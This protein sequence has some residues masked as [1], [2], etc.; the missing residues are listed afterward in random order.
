MDS[1]FLHLKIISYSIILSFVITLISVC[2]VKA[3]ENTFLISGNVMDSISM[4]ALS[5]VHIRSDESKIG[6]ISS[7]NGDFEF[8]ISEVPIRLSFSIIG[9]HKKELEIDQ[10]INTVL[11]IKLI[12]KSYE[13]T[14]VTIS[15]TNTYNK[16]INNYTVL[17]YGFIGDS[18]FILQKRRSIGGQASLVILNQ[19]FDTL[20]YLKKLP[21]GAHAIF[22]DCLNS[23]HVL[24][25]DSVY[26]VVCKQ[27]VTILYKPYAIDWFKKIMGDCIFKKDGNIFF[28]HILYQG[29]GHEV[30]YYDVQS[31]QKALFV[32]YIDFQ[33]FQNMTE[34]I[35]Y[36][37]SMYYLHGIVNA[38]TNDSATIKQGHNF[39]QES[40]FIKEIGDK[41][42]KNIICE[43][44][45]TIYYINYIESKIQSFSQLGQPPKE[46]LIDSQDD[47]WETEILKDEVNNEFYTCTQNNSDYYL[48][49]INIKK[50]IPEFQMKLSVFEGYNFQVNN[51]YLYYLNY[52]SRSVYHIRK[53]SRI[54]IQ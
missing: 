15:N 40:R 28:E 29:Y 43:N 50:G 4:K 27:G 17:D 38:S 24:T 5:N 12:P 31:K 47:G 8:S 16:K 44:N 7:Q 26:Q 52:P 35:S 13:L 1:S 32:R 33:N 49:R 2:S 45:D 39:S 6:I 48:Y 34:S 54:K 22:K 53:L 37:S 14:E 30:V 9:Y 21:K 11:K 36:I 10:L 51:G 3:Q 20:S 23:F 41:P 18:I 42:V 46:T 25:K 19:E